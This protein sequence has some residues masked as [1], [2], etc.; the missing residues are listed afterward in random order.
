MNYGIVLKVLGK[1]LFLES[2]LMMPSLLIALGLGEHD[3]R[4][5]VVTVAF[6]ATAGFV[7]GRIQ[8]EK[9]K[10]KVREGLSIVTLGWVVFSVFGALPF[11]LSGSL[12]FIDAFFEVVSGFTT[13]GATV[14]T[15]IE[16]LPKGLLFWR[17]LTHWI[18]GMGILIFTVAFMPTLGSGTFH[19]FKA[20]SP[21]PTADKIAPRMKDTAVILYT[22]Y[23]VIT[24]IEIILLKLGGMSLYESAL[25]TF[26]TVGTGGFST[27]NASIGAFNSTYIHLVIAF[28]MMFSGVNFSLYYKAFKG[29]WHEIF[30]N[31]ELRLYLGIILMATL[32]ITLNLRFS[33]YDSTWTAL[34]D[35]FFQVNSIITTTG[36]ATANFDLWPDFS[37]SILFLLMFTGASAGSTGGGI[38]IIRILFLFKLIRREISKIYHPRAMIPIRIGGKA[39]SGDINVS[40]ASFFALYIV[41]FVGGTVL[42]SL[43]GHGLVSAASA[44]AATIGNIGPGFDFVGPTQTYANFSDPSKLLLSF[45][46]LIGRLELYTVIAL[47]VPGQL[48]ERVFQS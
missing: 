28:F 41:A 26:G 29:K 7:M 40:I 33:V 3:L 35:S 13:T 2:A 1:L 6:T 21:G 25:H 5:F 44:V 12:N 10:M 31:E 14:V 16:I 23:I 42:I 9:Q 36:Y 48:R 22:T 47:I 11:V 17:S 4:A 20:E 45:L 34:R 27:R 32:A 37:K 39:L 15:D 19:L 24:L 8:V 30:Q 18:G 46:M 38:K 43:E